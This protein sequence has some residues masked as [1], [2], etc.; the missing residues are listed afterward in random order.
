MDNQQVTNVDLAWL[1][2]IWDGEGT[3]SCR[4]G[5]QQR[6]K[7]NPQFAPRVSMVNTDTQILHEVVRILDTLDIKY[8]FREKG[9]GGFE[10][11]RKPCFI[12]SVETL[13]NAARLLTA[14]RPYL[15]GK[16]FQADM[17]LKFVNSRLAKVKLRGRDNQK[18][19]YSKDELEWLD[20]VIQAN[21]N[22]RGTSETLR[23][24]AAREKADDK[25]RPYVKA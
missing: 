3:I 20:S 6:G 13:G 16:G 24:A 8:Y 9:V 17:M 4:K 5:V 10:G 11:S 1:A 12:I 19:A 14:I 15:R 7:K 23:E 21:G 18:F 2:G 25:V 22:P